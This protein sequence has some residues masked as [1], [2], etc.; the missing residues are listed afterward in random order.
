LCKELKQIKK[1]SNIRVI[2]FSASV[3]DAERLKE[4]LCD[5]FISKPFDINQLIQTIEKNMALVA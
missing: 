3:Q 5:D 2:I 4:Y 1:Y